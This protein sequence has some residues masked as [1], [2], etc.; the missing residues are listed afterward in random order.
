MTSTIKLEVHS[1]EEKNPQK[2]CVSLPEDV[3]RRFLSQDN[4]TVRK[5]F[6]EGSLFSPM[7]FGKFFDPSD[8]FPLWEFESDS[9]LSNLRNSGKCTVDWFQT[10][11]AYVLKAEVPGLGKNNAQIYVENGKILEISGRLRQLKETS[12]KDWRSCNWWEYGFVRRLELPE[13]SDWRKT[14]ATVNN[15]TLLEIRIPRIP[16]QCD[17]LEDSGPKNSESMQEH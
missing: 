4:Q 3:F 9:F 14:E 11:Q 5:V 8:G 6:G 15:D 7:L 13:D 1:L 12:T 2:W 17:N 16:S 10:D